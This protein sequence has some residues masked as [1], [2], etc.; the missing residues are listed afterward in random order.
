MKQGP[1]RPERKPRK[2]HVD[3]LAAAAMNHRVVTME[4][5]SITALS[6]PC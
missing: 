4:A 1:A 3:G 2:Q 6:A 5:L